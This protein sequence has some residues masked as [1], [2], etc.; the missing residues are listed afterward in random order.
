MTDYIYCREYGLQPAIQGYNYGYSEANGRPL[1]IINQSIKPDGQ[2]TDTR[3]GEILVQVKQVLYN[4]LITLK[5]FNGY[6]RIYVGKK[7]NF[8]FQK[9]FLG[10]GD[11]WKIRDLSGSSINNYKFNV[12]DRTEIRNILNEFLSRK[13]E[14]VFNLLYTTIREASG[15]EKFLAI[16]ETVIEYKDDFIPLLTHAEEVFLSVSDELIDK[17]KIKGNTTETGTGISNRSSST[18]KTILG[19]SLIGLGLYAMKKKKI[20]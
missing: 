19:L 1:V 3:T 20:I 15:L 8:Y 6:D 10:L 7:S 12:Y 4:K 9:V 2:T 18:T 13:Q 11:K 5:S 16:L 17:G 14:D